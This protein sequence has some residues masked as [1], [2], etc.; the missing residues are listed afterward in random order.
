LFIIAHPV[1][2][3]GNWEYNSLIE[4]AVCL[5]ITADTMGSHSEPRPT[6]IYSTRSSSS[7]MLPVEAISSAGDYILFTYSATDMFMPF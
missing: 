4:I 6:R 7:S 2:K 5:A 3:A 1:S